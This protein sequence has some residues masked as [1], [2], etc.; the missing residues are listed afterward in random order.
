MPRK[1]VKAKQPPSDSTQKREEERLRNPMKMRDKGT[2]RWNRQEPQRSGAVRLLR[3]SASPY[4]SSL[5]S[6][7][8]RSLTPFRFRRR[9]PS[10]PFTQVYTTS[11]GMGRH[12][13]HRNHT[14]I[15]I[16]ITRRFCKGFFTFSRRFYPKRRTK[17]K[18]IKL[19]AI[20]T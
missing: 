2:V 18:T 12:S 9:S 16:T 10:V 7:S 17:E 8:S 14:A 15:T 5:C 3:P 11:M 19:Q 13:L 1:K 6:S 4:L 20:E